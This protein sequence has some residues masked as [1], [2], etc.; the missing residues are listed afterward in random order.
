MLD[1]QADGDFRYR[2]FGSS[3]VQTY[4]REMTG[5]LLRETKTGEDMAFTYGVYRSAVTGR[6]PVI[7]RTT[8]TGELGTVVYDRV[9][10][11][12]AD[13]EGAVR[14]LL[15]TAKVI[16]PLPM[17]RTMLDAL[18]GDDGGDRGR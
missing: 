2:L 5:R 9:I 15:G 18:P 14:W 12:L 16:T 4:G 17:T 8:V 1:V 11:P 7:T 6:V 13:E 3:L 10:C